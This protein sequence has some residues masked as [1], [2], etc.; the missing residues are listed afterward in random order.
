MG[1]LLIG[2]AFLLGEK[3]AGNGNSIN[4]IRD[5]SY[6]IGSDSARVKI[7]EFGD[8]QCPACKATEPIIQKITQEYKDAI[9]FVYRHYPLPMHQNAEIAALA[10]EAAG[11]QG[12]FWEMHNLLFSNQS[13]WEASIR[14][15]DIITPFAEEL[16]LD[17]EIFLTDL[18]DSALK[19]KIKRDTEDGSYLGAN[20]TPTFF[21]NGEKFT[22][23]NYQSFKNKIDS[24]LH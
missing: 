1:L 4:L 12:K 20:S 8:F 3:P 11:R 13:S 16:G 21:I 18:D 24:L 17:K 23:T 7:V 2:A 14:P 5:D 9:Q 15:I 10:S 22:V 19:D 6:K